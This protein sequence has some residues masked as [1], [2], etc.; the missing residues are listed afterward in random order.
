[1]KTDRND[2]RGLAEMM[3]LGH[4][5]PVSWQSEKGSNDRPL[6]TGACGHRLQAPDIITS[7]S[8]SRP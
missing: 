3:R 5:R 7:M 1:V 2:A 8:Q 6:P 4:Y